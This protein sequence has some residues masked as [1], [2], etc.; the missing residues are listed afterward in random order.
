MRYPRLLIAPLQY[1]RQRCLN[2]CVSI[3][4][5]LTVHSESADPFGHNYCYIIAVCQFQPSHSVRGSFDVLAVKIVVY[6]S[7]E[8]DNAALFLLFVPRGSGPY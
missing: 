3:G 1:T 7:L 2:T 5:M 4:P 8:L 6:S